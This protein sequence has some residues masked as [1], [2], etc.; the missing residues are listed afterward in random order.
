MD[1]LGFVEAVDGCGEGIVVAV[2]DAADQ[3]LNARRGEPLGVFDRKVLHT[4]I[5]MMNEAAAPDG[6]ALVQGC[7]SASSTKPA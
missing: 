7:S 3:R 6:A 2:A 1:H 4:A 5:T